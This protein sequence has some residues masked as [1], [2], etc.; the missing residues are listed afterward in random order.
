MKRFSFVIFIVLYFLQQAI[1]LNTRL[2]G[3]ADTTRI[4]NDLI[5]ITKTLKSRNF[6]NVG[7]IDTVAQYIFDELSK[8]CDTV[9]Y[10]KFFVDGIEYKNVIGSIGQAQKEKIIIGAHYD[11]FLKQEG[12]DD[13][14]SGVSGLLELSRLLSKD[15]L[16][17]YIDFVAYALEEPPFF[18]S[19]HM[20]SY[21]H[22]KSLY[23][24]G[25]KIKGMICLEMIGYFDETPKSQRYPL[26]LLKL[27]YGNKG[28]YITVIQKYGN[29]SFGHQVKQLMQLQNL[30]STKSFKGP[31]WL[32]G[33]DFSDHRN[34]WKFKYK[35]VMITDTSFFRNKNYH[36]N[37]D[38][39]E[40]LDIRR[41]GLV[42]DELYLTVKQI[43]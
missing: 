14:A 32:R 16:K 12:A 10:Q 27:F 34:Y 2:N 3:Y 39:L 13:N 20:G 38:T 43:R 25:E 15:T 22:A 7:T 23:D 36:K 5:K 33:V 35:A 6:L 40:T 9:Y 1:G 8:T 42:I 11:V 41:M 19:E 26:G 31:Q 29:G 24:K 21:V 18:R 37:T 28:D 4:K 30:I 17:N